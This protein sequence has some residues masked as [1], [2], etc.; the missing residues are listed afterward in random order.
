MS[1]PLESNNSHITIF[2]SI[3]VISKEENEAS[4]WG[5]GVKHYRY[6]NYLI[7]LYFIIVTNS[8]LFTSYYMDNSK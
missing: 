8:I 5:V 1:D 6:V 4:G 7:N 2:P 3:Y